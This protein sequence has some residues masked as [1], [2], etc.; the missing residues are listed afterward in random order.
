MEDIKKGKQP[1]DAEIETVHSFVA[2]AKKFVGDPKAEVKVKPVKDVRTRDKVVD[3]M[4]KREDLAKQELKKLLG[5]ANSLPV[6]AIYHLSVIGAS[7]IAKGTV[8]LADFTEEMAK[9]F[10]EVVRPY[11]KQIYNKAVETFNLQSESMTR[12]RLSEVEKI[13]N[14]ALKGQNVGC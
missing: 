11:A 13:T 3:Y 4:S 1:T 9:E 8:K 12:Q 14:K 10:G 2:D 5:R 7:K 6:D